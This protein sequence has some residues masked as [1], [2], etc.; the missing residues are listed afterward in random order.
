LKI[1]I[2]KQPVQGGSIY[3]DLSPSHGGHGCKLNSISNFDSNVLRLGFGE[4]PTLNLVWGKI[5]A[6]TGE[7]RRHGRAG[8][9]RAASW[10]DSDT[11]WCGRRKEKKKEIENGLAGEY[12]PRGFWVF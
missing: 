2:A 6:A 8:P 4:D 12:G 3:R 9:L 5:A 11:G 7:G 10:A 1:H